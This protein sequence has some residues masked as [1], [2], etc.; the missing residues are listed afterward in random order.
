MAQTISSSSSNAVCQVQAS[1]GWVFD[2]AGSRFS[3]FSDSEHYCWFWVFKTSTIKGPL[4][5]FI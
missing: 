4:V 2:V 5:L 1:V 3:F